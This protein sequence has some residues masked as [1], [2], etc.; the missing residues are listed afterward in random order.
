MLKNMTISADVM[1]RHRSRH[2]FG[3]KALL[4]LEESLSGWFVH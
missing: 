1:P 4:S 3:K 2:S